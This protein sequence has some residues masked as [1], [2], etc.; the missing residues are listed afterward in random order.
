MGHFYTT[1][2]SFVGEINDALLLLS[3]SLNK[4]DLSRSIGVHL[5]IVIYSQPNCEYLYSY[6]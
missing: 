5:V 2:I 6:S 1:Y 3:K 4:L